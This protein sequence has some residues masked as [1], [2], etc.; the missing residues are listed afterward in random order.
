MN[1]IPDNEALGLGDAQR[2]AMGDGEL[3]GRVVGES[4]GEYRVW[5]GGREY[6]AECVGRFLAR[7]SG[8]GELPAVGDWVTL[9]ATDHNRARVRALLPRS[10]KFSRRAAGNRDD[11]QVVAANVD[12]AFIT[13]GLDG[14]FNLRRLERYLAVAWESGATPV[15]LL[16]KCDLVDDVG[17]RVEEAR[18][19]AGR[20]EVIAT[21]AVRGDGLD[22]VRALLA[23]R[24]T[25][26]F[27]GSSGVG[28]STVAN[29]LLAREAQ[30]TAGV[31]EHDQR[32]RHTTTHRELFVLPTG[33]L[34]IDT[35]GM[36]ELQLWD[37]SRGLDEAF[38][39]VTGCVAR[40][41][42][43]DCGHGAEPGCAVRE[44]LASG[45][46]DPERFASWRKLSVE[47]ASARDAR[48]QKARAATRGR[49][50]RTR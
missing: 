22:R 11:E 3:A 9:E 1:V 30:R 35:P 18:R 6:A 32:G 23:P 8:R 38:E 28:K 40:C 14:D 31:R 48:Q 39:D 46:L 5:A 44:A 29:A 47:A 45:A 7:A 43:R 37:V 4:K 42:F 16:T 36:R 49:P 17:A 15:V 33:A 19:V 27:M 2:A 41:R 50:P 24:V 10:T 25:V 34:L 26:A 13:A 20:A 12:V 21:S